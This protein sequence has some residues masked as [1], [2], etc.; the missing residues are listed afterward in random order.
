MSVP[1]IVEALHT[2]TAEIVRSEEFR[3][4][5]RDVVSE[6]LTAPRPEA[7]EMVP[8]S[9]FAREHSMNPATVR[10]LCKEGRVGVLAVVV[11]LTLGTGVPVPSSPRWVLV[12]ELELVV[13]AVVVVVRTWWSPSSPCSRPVALAGVVAELSA[14]GVA[15]EVDRSPEAAAMR[16]WLDP[17]TIPSR[18][19][20]VANVLRTPVAPGEC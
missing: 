12:A 15:V 16:P 18:P 7:V 8:P 5:L 1:S 2:L 4:A 20:R 10:R 11:D 13:L 14:A 3:A 17:M 6:M 19:P 9:V